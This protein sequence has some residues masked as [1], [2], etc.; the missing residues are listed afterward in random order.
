LEDNLHLEFDL[1][2]KKMKDDLN[3]FKNGRRPQSFGLW[4][5]TS[6]FIKWKNSSIFGEMEDDPNIFPNGRR[7]HFLEDGRQPQ[8][9]G[10]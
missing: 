3:F 9:I 7:P 5:T 4:K 10:N 6:T 2:L 1:N 8:L